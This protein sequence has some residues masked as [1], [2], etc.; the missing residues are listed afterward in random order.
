MLCSGIWY[1][2]TNVSEELSASIFNV[3][4]S[5]LNMEVAVY[6]Y[7]PHSF[8]NCASRPTLSDIVNFSRSDLNTVVSKQNFGKWISGEDLIKENTTAA[9]ET[10]QEI[11][12]VVHERFIAYCSC[13]Q[14]VERFR[15][16]QSLQS[17]KG[18]YINLQNCNF[19]DCT[20][21]YYS[22]RWE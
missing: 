11:F 10:L 2:G 1:L 12:V 8:S 20:G 7:V 15:F 3:E 16:L 5:T 14:A 18:T 9:G 6:Y 19:L 17:L 4:D 21:N 22:L 13:R